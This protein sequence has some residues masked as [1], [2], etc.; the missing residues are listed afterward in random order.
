MLSMSDGKLFRCPFAANADRLAAV[1]DFPGDYLDVLAEM[2]SPA[3][4]GSVGRKIMNYVLDTATLKVC[5]YCN[6][7]PL[8]GI[9]VPP[10]VQVDK[11]LVY[12]KHLRNP[13]IQTN[14]K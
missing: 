4:A 13:N 14:E 12:V 6:G 5:D 8:A 11:P 3:G 7:R 10:A 1:P 9:E 2:K